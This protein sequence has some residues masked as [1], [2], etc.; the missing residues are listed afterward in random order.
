MQKVRL[1]Y[2]LTSTPTVVNVPADTDLI[3]YKKSGSAARFR[4][5]STGPFE[6]YLPAGE[7]HTTVPTGNNTTIEFLKNGFDPSFPR[8]TH[9]DSTP[10]PNKDIPVILHISR[11]TS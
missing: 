6:F 5:G 10:N 8:I 9:D 3:I 4:V 11:R 1:V 7:F 2:S